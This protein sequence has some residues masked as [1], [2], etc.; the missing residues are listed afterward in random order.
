MTVVLYNN[1]PVDADPGAALDFPES[2][3]YGWDAIK[4]IDNIVDW[5]VINWAPFFDFI[6]AVVIGILIPF[7]DF[8]IWLPWWLVIIV[9]T[10]GAWRMVNK[11]FALIAAEKDMPFGVRNAKLRCFTSLFT[12]PSWQ[13]GLVGSVVLLATHSSF[14]DC[15]SIPEA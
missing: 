8:L 4:W 12:K 5:V 2:M 14:C 11:W 9:V 15:A 6:L 10:L 13:I 1:V 7:R 3:D